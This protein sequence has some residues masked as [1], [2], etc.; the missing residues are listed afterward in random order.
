M[1]SAG[2]DFGENGT[3][4]LLDFAL[5]AIL[6]EFPVDFFQLLVEQIFLLAAIDAAPDLGAD[7]ALEVGELRFAFDGRFDGLKP[8]PCIL[9][10]EEFPLRFELQRKGVRDDIC[11]SVG[12]S[13]AFDRRQ[14]FRSD[15]LREFAVFFETA[16]YEA[17]SR[18]EFR[19]RNGFDFAEC[20]AECDQMIQA[21]RD[22][23][24]FYARLALDQDAQ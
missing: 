10:F 15:L 17:Q 16:L 8:L 22:A 11:Q 1:T 5:F 23:S 14:D 3:F 13:L 24:D 20:L 6:A 18:L 4:K 19:S 2:G 7:P 21:L 12:A 9:D